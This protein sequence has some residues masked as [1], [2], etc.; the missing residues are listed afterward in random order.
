MWESINRSIFRGIFLAFF[1]TFICVMPLFFMQEL[2][3]TRTFQQ[4]T[5]KALSGNR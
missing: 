4:E 1:M 2:I 5:I 3:R